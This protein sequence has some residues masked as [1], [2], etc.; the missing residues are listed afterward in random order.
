MSILTL[1]L[2]LLTAAAAGVIANIVASLLEKYA[3]NNA[4]IQKLSLKQRL[5]IASIFFLLLSLSS[6][7]SQIKMIQIDRNNINVS[8]EQ[9]EEVKQSANSEMVNITENSTAILF[10]GDISISVAGIYVNP[11]RVDA[12]FGSPGYPTGQIEQQ[13][14][15]Y[16]TIYL[17]KRKYDIR[18]NRIGFK[19]FALSHSVDFVVT[20]IE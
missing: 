18:I 2:V 7:Y 11:I 12:K 4:T 8:S 17:S 10:N 15:G 13:G 20:R 14:V 3:G 1:L 6:F 5:A 19:G 9:Q 16:F